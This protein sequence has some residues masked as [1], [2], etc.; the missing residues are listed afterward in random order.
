MPS[1]RQYKERATE[2]IVAL[3]QDPLTTR[4]IPEQRPE[5][6]RIKGQGAFIACWVWVSDDEFANDSDATTG[7][8]GD[9]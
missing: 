1:D 5:V 2:I 3:K 7:T 9:I 6:Q 8:K 4:I